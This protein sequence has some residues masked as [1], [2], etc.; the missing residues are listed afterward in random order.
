MTF[1]DLP[2]P[3]SSRADDLNYAE[4]MAHIRAKLPVPLQLDWARQSEWFLQQHEPG[5]G[6]PFRDFCERSR[7]KRGELAE[8]ASLRKAREL[9]FNVL[10]FEQAISP[11]ICIFGIWSIDAISVCFHLNING[12]S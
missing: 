12:T 5:S 9:L 11:K 10:G 3:S 6:P 1:A 4:G 7:A 2:S 8:L